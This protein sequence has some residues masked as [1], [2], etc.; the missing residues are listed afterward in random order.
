MGAP[1]RFVALIAVLAAAAAGRT[2][3]AQ[4]DTP[5]A[6]P[7]NERGPS[8]APVAVVEYCTYESD[9]CAQLEVIVNVLAVEFGDRV[10]FVFRHVPSA[11]TAAASLRYR[12]ALAAGAQGRFWPMHDMLLA[13]RERAS[14]EDVLAMASQLGLEGARF[15]ADLDSPSIAAAAKQDSD[16]AAS[17]GITA[18]PTV[19]VN[20]RTL[21]SVQDAR[22]VR[23]AIRQAL[24]P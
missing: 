19:I 1:V 22:E 2:V 15:R 23:A 14:L 5:G 13:N 11:Q 10:R 7:V 3:E 18:T 16:E 9:A 20:G 6:A 8:N 17:K 24:I 12:A 4:T 21:P